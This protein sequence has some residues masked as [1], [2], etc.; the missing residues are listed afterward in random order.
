MLSLKTNFN[1]LTNFKFK[2]FSL[3]ASLFLAFF[4]VGCS[5]DDKDDEGQKPL[6]SV[7]SSFPA[8]PSATF[9]KIEKFIAYDHVS[10][11]DFNAFITSIEADG[12]TCNGVECDKTDPSGDIDFAYSGGGSSSAL[13]LSDERGYLA[14]KSLVNN[15]GTDIDDDNFETLFPAINGREAIAATVKFFSATDVTAAQANYVE[16]LE[17]DG[18]SPPSGG[19]DHTYTKPGDGVTYEVLVDYV[20]GSTTAVMW[21]VTRDDVIFEDVVQLYIDHFRKP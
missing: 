7:E 21:V 4:L 9:S 3:L 14:L 15:S 11:D 10:E 6:P 20:D 17:D 12:F 19:G 13:S 8:L 5:N 1:A 18:F 2:A 16:A